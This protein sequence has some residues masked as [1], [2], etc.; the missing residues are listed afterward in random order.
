MSEKFETTKLTISDE[1]IFC[2]ILAFD[3]EEKTININA[4]YIDEKYRGQNLSYSIIKNGLNSCKKY[5]KGINDEWTVTVDDCSDRYRQSHNLYIN[6]GFEY[7]DDQSGP[8]M[9]AKLYKIL[10]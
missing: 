2:I 9:H 6:I 5:I 1:N 4:L 7:V 10:Q 8:E 3:I